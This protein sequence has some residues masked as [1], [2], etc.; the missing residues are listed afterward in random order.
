[1]PHLKL[2][3]KKAS[4]CA[5][6]VHCDITAFTY[7]LGVQAGGILVN[8]EAEKFF[9]TEL[10]YAASDAQFATE[11]FEKEKKKFADRRQDK[12]KIRVGMNS[13][14]NPSINVRQGVLTLEGWAINFPA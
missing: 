6:S 14:N 5:S 1:L 7:L 11:E 8:G 9:T 3:E 2:K 10:G 12:V 4:S 13:L